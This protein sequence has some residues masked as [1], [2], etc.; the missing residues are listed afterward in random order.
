MAWV[1]VEARAGFAPFISAFQPRPAP[2]ACHKLNKGVFGSFTTKFVLLEGSWKIHHLRSSNK[3]I[4]GQGNIRM[5]DTG[6]I[7]GS[8]LT[9]HT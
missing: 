6:L 1:G 5:V 7:F 8:P 3:D 2:I 4:L 9:T